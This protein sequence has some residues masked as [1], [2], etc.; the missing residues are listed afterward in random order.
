MGGRPMI[1]ATVIRGFAEAVEA[2]GGRPE[3]LLADLGLD[4]TRVSQQES[5]LACS[6]FAALLEAAAIETGDEAFGLHFGALSNPKEVGALSYALLNAPT[7][8]ASF[9]AAARYL[10][11]HNQAVQPSVE[12]A[13]SLV[14]LR[15]AHVN[16]GMDKPRQLNEYSMAVALNLLRMMAGSLWSPREVQFAHSAPHDASEEVRFFGSPVLYD[17][18]TNAMVVEREF[19][20]SKIPAADPRLFEIMR[21]YLDDI[22]SKMPREDGFLCSVRKAIAETM[23]ESSPSL[24]AVAQKLATS[25]RTLQ[26]QLK[27]YGVEFKSLLNDTR[28]QFA[29]EYLKYSNDTLTQIAFLLGY[30]E[31]SAF[32]RAFRK[33]TGKTPLSYRRSIHPAD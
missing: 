31:V 26:R 25:P 8:A 18:P 15:Y 9:D 20:Q 17:C 5:Y 7:I 22:L 1:A 30:S 23:R 32:N 3:K 4:A 13:H 27:Q 6:D 28:R 21:H 16:I 11:V 12:T 29:L 2:A 24:S 33:W 19:Y 10:H 14:Y